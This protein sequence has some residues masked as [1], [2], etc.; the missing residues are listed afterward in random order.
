MMLVTAIKVSQQRYNTGGITMANKGFF[1]VFVWF[2][3]FPD[4]CSLFPG[5]EKTTKKI[6]PPPDFTQILIFLQG[7][8]INPDFK[9]VLSSF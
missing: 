3:A 6:Q 5:T 4:S 2:F 7:K 9:T 1:W 8:D